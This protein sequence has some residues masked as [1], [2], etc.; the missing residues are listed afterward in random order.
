MKELIHVSYNADICMYSF[1][2]NILTGSFF[3]EKPEVG[4]IFMS[5]TLRS[6]SRPLN[7]AK[8]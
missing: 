7:G 3:K 1:K 5:H 8:I 6:G 4:D 2:N